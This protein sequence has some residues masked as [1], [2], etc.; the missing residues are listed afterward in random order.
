MRVDVKTIGDAKMKIDLRSTARGHTHLCRRK[1]LNRVWLTQRQR[2]VL[3]QLQQKT[4][5]GQAE[6]YLPPAASAFLMLTSTSFF[7][8]NPAVSATTFPSRPTK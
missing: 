7:D 4:Q 5:Y 8:T 1:K 6:H 3:E 2:G